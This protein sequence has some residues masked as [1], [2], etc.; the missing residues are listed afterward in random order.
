MCLVKFLPFMAIIVNQLRPLTVVFGILHSLLCMASWAER[1]AA[2]DE[3]RNVVFILT[4]DQRDNS[5]SAMGHPWIRTP[6][7]DALLAR[8]TR[9]RSTYVAEPICNPSRASLLLGCH[10]RTHRLG[11]SSKHRMTRAQ[12]ADG[13]PALL[14]KA[15]Y[16][17]GFVGKWHVDTDGFEFTSLFDFC[18]GHRGHGPF[19]FERKDAFGNDQT[20]TTNRHHTDNAIRF[21]D[22][23]TSGQPF[24]L[25]ICYATPH[26]SKVRKM[27]QPLDESA[28]L[29][30][31]LKDH[32]IYGGLYRDLD[33]AYP[34]QTPE[35]PYDHIPRHVMDQEAGRA[36]T[37]AFDYDAKSNRE[38]LFR[39]YQM[40]TELDQMVGELVDALKERDLDKNTVIIYGSDHGLLLGEYGRG[41]KGLLYDLTSKIPCFIFDPAVAETTG[42]QVREE[43]VSSTDITATILDCAGVDP[44]P[45]MTG[46]S[47]MPLVRS[48]L[49]SQSWR[50]GLF[51]ESLYTG[52]DTPLQEGYIEDGWKYVRCFKADH[53]YSET[54]LLHPGQDP[55]WEMLFHLER[56][57]AEKENRID[58]PSASLIADSL[59][60]KCEAAVHEMNRARI[61]YRAQYINP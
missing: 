27:H 58:D 31:K 17:T 8:S 29:N 43:L 44:A 53:P 26:G 20:V 36:K 57:P 9:F 11:F 33:I 28:S 35:N 48:K 3:R 12:W 15:K 42:G 32:P 2:A 10:E 56:D 21:L 4:D 39:Y 23:V 24:C 6:R 7:V 22:S 25:S 59:R 37:Y 13:Y 61:H 18:D 52:R 49:P 14:Q 54:Q 45:F 55:V 51:L 16:R 19:F 41:G 1:S 30:P 34:L 38:H 5:F 40:I 47:L 60:A 50:T 46:R